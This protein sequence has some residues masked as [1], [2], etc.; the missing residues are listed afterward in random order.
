MMELMVLGF[1]LKVNI[2]KASEI[3]KLELMNCQCD[4]ELNQKIS[5]TKC[6]I[7][8]LIA[9]RKNSSS[10]AN[11]TENDCNVRWHVYVNSFSP[12]VNHIVAKSYIY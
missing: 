9:E 8:V 11:I 4:T 7:F 5:K 2:E 3:F 12:L 10:Q 1:S 6:K